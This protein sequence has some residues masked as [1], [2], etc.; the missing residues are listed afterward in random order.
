M[1][2]LWLW[3]RILNRGDM[4]YS[5]L[6][7]LV[8]ALSCYHSSYKL[9]SKKLLSLRQPTN[10]NAT[11]VTANNCETKQCDLKWF[12]YHPIG[13]SFAR[14]NSKNSI[15]EARKWK[16]GKTNCCCLLWD[17]E[18]IGATGLFHLECIPPPPNKIEK[19]TKI[20]IFVIVKV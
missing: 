17:L 3:N 10:N 14:E 12:R 1:V 16:V 11:W 13:I 7:K 15:I 5:V 19:L 6:I 4:I 8:K 20:K 18:N 2:T 9:Y